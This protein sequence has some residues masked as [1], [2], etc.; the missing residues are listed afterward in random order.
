MKVEVET[1]ITIL[2][3]K[4]EGNTFVE[5][6]IADTEQRY[7]ELGVIE[8]LRYEWNKFI[9]YDKSYPNWKER[10][11]EQNINNNLW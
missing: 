8:T 7:T 9:P 3:G 1:K 10:A 6:T 4:E 11:N 2:E 5:K